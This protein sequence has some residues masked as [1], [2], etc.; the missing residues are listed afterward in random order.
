MTQQ[1]RKMFLEVERSHDARLAKNTNNA[2]VAEPKAAD[3]RTG[4]ALTY[5]TLS[6]IIIGMRV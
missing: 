6:L 3:K 1:P 4:C 2:R 5:H